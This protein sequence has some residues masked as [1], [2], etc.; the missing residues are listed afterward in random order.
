MKIDRSK[1]TIKTLASEEDDEFVD[2]TPSE[3]VLMVWPLTHEIWD[4]YKPGYA[5]QRL[6]RNI[7]ALNRSE[8]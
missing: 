2:A 3:R 6:Q 7:T 4:I 5:E 8:S 1:V